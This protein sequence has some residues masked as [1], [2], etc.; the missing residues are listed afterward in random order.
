MANSEDYLKKIMFYFL[1]LDRTKTSEASVFKEIPHGDLCAK[2]SERIET[3]LSYF[4]RY[5]KISYI[6]HGLKEKGSDVA[7]RYYVGDKSRFI[8]FQVNSYGDLKEADYL[9]K[10]KAQYVDS[11]NRYNFEDYYV[12]L[13]TDEYTER[14]KIAGIKADLISTAKLTIIDPSQ[15]LFFLRLK[16]AQVGAIVKAYVEDGDLV[17]N[18]ARGKIAGLP[19]T[20]N[21]LIF[22]ILDLSV[23]KCFSAA[24][25]KA[26]ILSCKYLRDVYESFSAEDVDE[27]EYDEFVS[28]ESDEFA[29]MVEEDLEILS[30]RGYFEFDPETGKIIPDQD[31]LKPIVCLTLEG[32][33]RYEFNTQ[34]TVEYLEELLLMGS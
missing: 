33:L 26:D 24:L 31:Y 10:I 29:E 9:K 20:Q 14:R 13:A 27:D 3:I 17:V 6:L 32:Q 23:R 21:C 16:P 25:E 5:R 12:I 15:F 2:L 4:E 1:T 19:K 34:E 28:Y 7:L 8:C 22:L 18:K 30:G 11:Q